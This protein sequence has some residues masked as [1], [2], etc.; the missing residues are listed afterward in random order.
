MHETEAGHVDLSRLAQIGAGVTLR[1]Y[2]ETTPGRHL[3]TCVYVMLDASGSMRQLCP[4]IDG[5]RPSAGWQ[6]IDEVRRAALAIATACQSLRVPFA[7]GAYDDRCWSVSN[8]G[9]P[10]NR[11][12]AQLERIGGGGG[13]AANAAADFVRQ[14]LAPRRERRR[15][16][17]ILCDGDTRSD[18]PEWRALAAARIDFRLAILRSSEAERNI[19]YMRTAP[20]WRN[21]WSV[22]DSPMSAAR[23]M[24]DSL[25]TMLE[26][27]ARE[28]L[29]AELA[30]V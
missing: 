29:A 26:L 8:F 6:P 30:G 11:V 7:C 27:G 18:W 1:P 17:L 12:R 20:H 13:T 23:D 2:R 25:R 9:D 22:T 14:Q 28:D 5:V 3:A 4:R 24:L 21:R 19:T 16:A 15:V 10:L